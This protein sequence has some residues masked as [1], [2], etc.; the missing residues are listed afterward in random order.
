MIIKQSSDAIKWLYDANHLNCTFDEFVEAMKEWSLNVICDHEPVAVIAVKD[1]HG[2]IAS[3]KGAKVGI[4]RM[5]QAL[6]MLQITKTTVR[7]DYARG[8]VL[9]KRLGFKKHHVD[10]VTHY[11]LDTQ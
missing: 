5:R 8:H 9:A 6:N 7:N 1:G 4:I 11:V 10:K 2:H 3:V